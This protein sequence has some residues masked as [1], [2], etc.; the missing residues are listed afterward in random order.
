MNYGAFAFKDGA[1]WKVRAGPFASEGDA[2]A[3]VE[4]IRKRLGGK[5]FVTRAPL[6]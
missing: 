2:Q 4:P 5:P 6:P 3:A 1:Y